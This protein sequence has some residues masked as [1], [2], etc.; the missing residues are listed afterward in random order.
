[1]LGLADVCVDSVVSLS[2]PGTLGLT[3]GNTQGNQVV[4]LGVFADPVHILTTP[5]EV[6]N[7]R[8]QNQSRLSN[9]TSNIAAPHT[10]GARWPQAGAPPLVSGCNA[11]IKPPRPQY[12]RFGD[13]YIDDHGIED[14]T[15][16]N[17]PVIPVSATAL[18]LAMADHW[19]DPVSS[20]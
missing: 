14:I 9:Y 8:Q 7:A 2:P 19:Q 1:M 10:V 11:V 16:V 3:L 15:R 18:M 5:G 12:I 13:C 20:T 6:Y 17:Q 4:G